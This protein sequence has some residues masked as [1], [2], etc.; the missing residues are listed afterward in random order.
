MKQTK[1]AEAVLMNFTVDGWNILF[2]EAHSMFRVYWLQITES[3]MQD[4]AMVTSR[5]DPR[6]QTIQILYRKKMTV[7]KAEIDHHNLAPIHLIW[8]EQSD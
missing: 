4:T 8:L 5:S 6:W 2:Q 7:Y 3:S 1:I